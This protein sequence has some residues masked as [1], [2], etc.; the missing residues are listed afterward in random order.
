MCN[1]DVVHELWL[2]IDEKPNFVLKECFIYSM[3]SDWNVEL[4]DDSVSDFEVIFKGPK[5]S[6][7]ILQFPLPELE[8]LLTQKST[9]ASV[10]LQ[11]FCASST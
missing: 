8:V 4:I 10:K 9:R 2:S 11:Y 1:I 5:E 3:M 7:S 6:K